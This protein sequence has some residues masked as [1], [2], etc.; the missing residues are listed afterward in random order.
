MKLLSLFFTLLSFFIISTEIIAQETV[1]PSRTPE[2]QK[3][4][5]ALNQRWN[6]AL[7][8]FQIQVVNSRINPTVGV[9]IIEKIEANR[10]ETEIVYIPLR[11]NVRIMILPN[12]EIQKADFVKIP[13][14]QYIQE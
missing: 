14:F 13:Y 1:K 7:G 4:F 10:K 12:R 5:D 6:K 3:V 11:E 2:E 8:T 9:E